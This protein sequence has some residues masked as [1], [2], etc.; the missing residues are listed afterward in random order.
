M[1]LPSNVKDL[2]YEELVKALVED[3]GYTEDAAKYIAGK[4]KGRIKD[5][6]I[7]Q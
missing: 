4:V 5:D 3:E 7:V 1:I 2:S 6:N